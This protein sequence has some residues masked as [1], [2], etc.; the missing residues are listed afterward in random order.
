MK[1]LHKS[2]FSSFLF[3]LKKKTEIAYHHP[4][5]SIYLAGLDLHS[6]WLGARDM[7]TEGDWRW[8]GSGGK[9]P[10]EAPFWAL[11]YNTSNRLYMIVSKIWQTRDIGKDG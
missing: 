10:M 6:Y 5:I 8:E 2:F 11:K 3:H 7:W 9:V 4:S 1:L